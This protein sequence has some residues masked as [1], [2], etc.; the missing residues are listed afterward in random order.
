[1]KKIIFVIISIIIILAFGISEQIYMN[2]TLD[3]L[4][5]K[6]L[7]I[8]TLLKE[9]NPKAKEKVVELKFWWYEKRDILEFLYPNTDIKD[10]AREIGELEGSI[11]N[12]AEDDP[13]IRCNV[14]QE[15]AKNSKNLLSF[16]WKNIL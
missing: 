10:I 14:L 3:T 8:Q 5:S 2:K 13:L 16:K 12:D 4:E 11:L 15:M 7:E 1:M 9:D 6:S